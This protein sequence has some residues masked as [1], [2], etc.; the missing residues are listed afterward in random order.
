M[1]VFA[2]ITFLIKRLQAVIIPTRDIW[3]SIAIVVALDLLDTEKKL[4]GKRLHGRKDYT[5]GRLDGEELYRRK[6]TLN[7]GTTQLR[8][9]EE[10]YMGKD[11]IRR[12]YTERDYI[13]ENYIEK[14]L[15][16]TK[17]ELYNRGTTWRG[18]IRRGII[19]GKTI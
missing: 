6:I 14:R 15:Y 19:R 2:D 18:T 13:G 3:D 5:E 12:D 4:Y 10:R 9:Y 7:K 8:N 16:Y 17:K 11:Y 1:S